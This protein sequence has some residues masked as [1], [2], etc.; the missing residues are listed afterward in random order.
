VSLKILALSGSLRLESVADRIIQLSSLKIEQQG[1]GCTLINLKTFQLPFCDGSEEYPAFPDVAVLRE[2]FQTCDG[3]I[4][5]TPEYHGCISGVLKNTLDLLSG[6][7]LKGK[8]AALVGI[9]GGAHSS[10]AANS[11]RIILRQLHAWVLPEQLLIPHADQAL[12]EGGRLKD[13]QLE[14][15]LTELIHHLVISTHKLRS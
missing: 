12:D 2:H 13:E 10:N 11:L 7:E 6:H 4:I 5:A 14:L 15:R 3:L 8:V 1:V 9:L